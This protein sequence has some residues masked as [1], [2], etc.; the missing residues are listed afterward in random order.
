MTKCLNFYRFLFAAHGIY[1]KQSDINLRIPI[2][3]GAPKE[4]ERNR[5]IKFEIADASSN[6]N[7]RFSMSEKLE[8]LHLNEETGELWFRRFKWNVSLTPFTW[9]TISKEIVVKAT[10]SEDE[11]EANMK[12]SLHFTPYESLKDFCEHQI[13]FY[14]GITYN[15]YE[16]YG[17]NFKSREIGQ[18]TP[19]FYQRIC[20]DYKL[21]YQL[22]NGKK[23]VF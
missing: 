15:T 10:S 21:E 22:L 8:Y 7:Y 9:K 12:I 6:A 11:E 19:K 17:E 16:D 1:F 5:L 23:L 2:V 13:C 4:H 14:D 18:I 3:S 20:R